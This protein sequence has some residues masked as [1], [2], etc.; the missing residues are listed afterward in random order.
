[1]LPGLD[2]ELLLGG[3]P[4]SLDEPLAL[5][6][7][8]IAFYNRTQA[9]DQVEGG[10]PCGGTLPQGVQGTAVALGGAALL[11]GPQIETVLVVSLAIA[12]AGLCVIARLVVYMA[13]VAA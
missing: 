4:D 9:G 12:A 6:L 8:Q 13:E 7:L 11:L 1:M 10:T 5:R 2:E 3:V